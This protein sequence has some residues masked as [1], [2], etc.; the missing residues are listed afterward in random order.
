MVFERALALNAR[1]L[2]R[3]APSGGAPGDPPGRVARGRAACACGAPRAWCPCPR[4][5]LEVVEPG[6]LVVKY[7]RGD[8]F[9]K[10]GTI[11]VLQG[12]RIME[13]DEGGASLPDCPALL[14]SLLGF[15]SPLPTGG[16]PSVLAQLAV[17]MRAHG[18]GG[19]LIVVPAESDAWRESGD[20][21]H[22]LPVAPWADLA[23]LLAAGDGERER[24]AWR[25]AL[26]RAVEAVAGLT[27]VDG[28]TVLNERHEVLAFGVKLVQQARRRAG[29]AA[30]PS[31]RRWWADVSKTVDPGVLG[32]TR[33]PLR[34][35]VRARPARRARHGRLAGRPLHR[36]RLVA[37][38]G[39][40]A[41]PP[42][43]NAAHVASRKTCVA[44]RWSKR[45]PVRQ[46]SRAGV[47]A[48]LPLLL[49]FGEG[50][51]GVPRII[52]RSCVVPG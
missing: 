21:P 11:A 49:R 24:P 8:E 52:I 22:P 1:E 35:P 18:R 20:A 31:P 41:R 44:R 19:S 5:V 47:V 3:L 27:A 40:G 2:A 45:T 13:V 17:S 25:D 32:G 28:A 51:L 33:H 26:H 34:R 46:P 30:W 12:D 15:D 6:L 4:W 43:R 10:F 14:S 7:R 9:D 38:R 50:G 29:G 48:P 36:V 37:L 23:Q 16:A 39:H 42:R